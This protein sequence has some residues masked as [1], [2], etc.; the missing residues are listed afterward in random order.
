MQWSKFFRNYYRYKKVEI[1]VKSGK[2][3]AR[4]S[5]VEY[6]STICIYREG[7]PGRESGRDLLH[8]VSTV[9]SNRQLEN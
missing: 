9:N 3:F 6:C 8:G 4:G 1:L 7:I 2:Y 5:D